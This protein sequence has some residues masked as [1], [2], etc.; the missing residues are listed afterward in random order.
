MRREISYN[1]VF[2]HIDAVILCGGKGTRLRRVVSDRPKPMAQINGTPFLDILIGY[3]SCFGFRRFVLC[4]GYLSDVIEDHFS[5]PAADADIEVVI[6]RWNR[7][8]P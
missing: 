3:L 8:R 7:R 2:Q 5:R 1:P 6:S 4:T